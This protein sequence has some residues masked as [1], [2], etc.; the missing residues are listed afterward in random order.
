[1]R[2]TS[3]QSG[4]L[5]GAARSTPPRDIARAL[6]QRGIDPVPV[7]YREKAPTTRDWSS[8]R[9]T[10][11]TVDGVFP[12]GPGNVGM[13]LRGGLVDIDLDSPLAVA[14]APH[15]LPPTPCRYGRE[16]KRNSH[17]L[18]RALGSRYQAFQDPAPGNTKAV[19]VEIRTGDAH[20][21]VAPGSVHPSGEQYEWEPEA[22][23]TPAPVDKDTLRGCVEALAAA[24]LVAP[25]W[26]EGRHDDLNVTLTG[27]LL[28][29]GWPAERIVQFVRPIATVQGDDKLSER[30][31][32]IDRLS[33]DYEAGKGRVRG[34][35][36]LRQAIGAERANAVAEWLRLKD[37]SP[38]IEL[39]EFTEAELLGPIAPVRYLIDGR[40]PTEAY[41][42]IAGGLSSAKTTLLHLFCLQRATG[43]NFVDAGAL[44]FGMTEDVGPVALISYEDSDAHILRRFQTQVQYQH[45][46]IAEV[47]GRQSA[48]RYVQR[49][50][51]NVRRVTLTGR[52]G[53][54]LVARA[55]RAVVWNTAL[56]DELL[57][58]VRGFASEGVMIGL[59]PLRLAIVGSQNDD[60]GA[61]VVVSVLNHLATALPHSALVIPSHTTKAQARGESNGG[62]A[63]AAYATSGSALYSQHARSNF[64]MT[65]LQAQKVR[66]L[67]PHEQLTDE[68]VA[69]QRIVQLTHGRLSHGAESRE[70]HFV[71]RAGVLVPLLDDRRQE[72]AMQ[73]LIRAL[74]VVDAAIREIEREG[75]KASAMLLESDKRLRNKFSRDQVRTVLAGLDAQGWVTKVGR[76]RN[77]RLCVTEAGRAVISRERV[78]K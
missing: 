40:V 62:W 39:Q 19:L 65:R 59:D 50:V 36:A 21:S 52:A 13:I 12:D 67:F 14:L 16:S 35:P 20:Q 77:T 75:G 72:S 7:R 27:V 37:E 51:R 18:Y 24:C 71:M 60:E 45:K 4:K 31:D 56:L 26:V 63:D 64:H 43:V 9:V 33:R 30:L 8:T 1:M 76:T 32:R 61:E 44:E 17:F 23:Q 28:R 6:L 58:H 73:A 49:V 10:E 55:E 66:E 54:G 68:E 70:L 38:V 41:T 15:F 34:L 3:N 48:E 47:H 2:G 78:V 42:L 25:F 5:N 22:D 53:T 74:P 69:Q 29:A 46:R 57:R 11:G